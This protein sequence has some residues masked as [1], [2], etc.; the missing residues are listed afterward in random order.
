MALELE[1]VGTYHRAQQV[2]DYCQQVR[3]HGNTFADV[4]I[5]AEPT[6]TFDQNALKVL[7]LSL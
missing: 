4:W 7:R 3:M 5:E 2:F 1:L 6:N